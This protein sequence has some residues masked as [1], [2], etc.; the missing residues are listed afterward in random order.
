MHVSEINIYPIKSCRGTSLMSA[1]VEPLGFEMD[2]RWLLVDKNGTFLTQR[3]LPKMATIKVSLRGDAVEV[4]ADGAQPM[5]VEPLR[6][7][8]R[9][10]VRVWKS[11]SEALP[12][13]FETNKWFSDVL[14]EE[15]KLLYMP[16]DAGRPVNPLFDRDGDLVSFAD[17]YP[18]M[19]L[20]EASLGDLNARLE[21]PLPMNRFRPNLVVAGANAFAEDNWKRIKIGDAVFRSTKPCERCVI[22][23]VEPSRGE[24]DGKEPLKTLAT[25]RMA[26]HFMP[27]RIETMGVDPNGVLFG[28]NL[29]PETPG[30]TIRVG[31]PVTVLEKF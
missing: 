12:C 17:G 18:F 20:S 2:R 9:K 27:D 7:G 8:E 16:D 21:T 14:G 6:D 5:T 28:Q 1:V 29:I 11:E 26:K 19:L 4:H 24:F 22:T 15:V 13:D 10:F 23:T 30:V 31:D 25:Y 3:E